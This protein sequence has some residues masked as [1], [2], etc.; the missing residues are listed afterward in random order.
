MSVEIIQVSKS[1]VTLGRRK[2]VFKDLTI[3]FPR[4]LSVGVIGPNGC[5]KSTLLRLIAGADEPDR[6]VIKRNMRL[7]W[8]IGFGGTANVNLSGVANA[9]FCARLYGADPEEVVRRT[10]EFA[11]LGEMM[12]W[13][14]KSYSSGMRSRLNFA[15]SM[16]VDF[17]CLLIDEILSVG[18]V[19]FRAKCAGALEERRGRAN[20]ILVSH[21]ARD[22]VRMCERVVILGPAQ[23][24]ISDDVPYALKQFA[25][26]LGGIKGARDL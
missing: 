3:S 1:Y 18:D 26:A 8:P 7:S 11:G 20:F 13:P 4:N 14:V 23:P 16:A 2:Q 15:I 21:N 19:D 5:G 25:S 22:I 6:G 9:R 12:H 17:E 10:T 24:I